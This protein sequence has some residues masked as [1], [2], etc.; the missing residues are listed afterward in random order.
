MPTWTIKGG[1]QA[2]GYDVGWNTPVTAGGETLLNPQLTAGQSAVSW[3]KSTDIAGTAV[4][5][6]GHG[7]T[8]GNLV[9]VYWAGG[10]RVGM[11]ATVTVDSVAL[12]GG[13][14]TALPANGTTVILCVQVAIVA[15]FVGNSLAALF[16]SATIRSV[17]SFVDNTAAVTS[18]EILPNSGISYQANT[19][20]LAGKTIVSG[21]LSTTDP[22]AEAPVLYGILF[23]ATPSYPG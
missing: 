20:P 9:D 19:N 12:S 13:S 6:Y 15:A 17:I 21:S 14:G 1:V 23:D 2:A 10:Y 22:I 11:T 3:T 5:Y 18:F 8:T 4:M 7:I 16:A